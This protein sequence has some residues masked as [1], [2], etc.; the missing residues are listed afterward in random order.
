MIE[1]REAGMSELEQFYGV[2][3]CKCG[4]KADMSPDEAS[5]FIEA[6][7]HFPWLTPPP[8]EACKSKNQNRE[9]Q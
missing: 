8:C 9:P 2:I 1:N 4:K 3:L 7:S 5:A 6:K